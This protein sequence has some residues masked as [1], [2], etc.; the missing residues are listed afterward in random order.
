MPRTSEKNQALAGFTSLTND[1]GMGDQL[2]TQL[3]DEEEEARR[4]QR[5]AGTAPGQPM[6]ARANPM[7]SPATMSLFGGMGGGYGA[8]GTFLGR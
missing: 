8:R 5:L 1:L 6:L 4:R 7:L 3:T 2:R